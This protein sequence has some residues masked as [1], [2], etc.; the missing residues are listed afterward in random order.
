MKT[1]KL[2]PALAIALSVVALSGCT[3]NKHV[4]FGNYWNYDSMTQA[5]IQEK[6]TYDIVYEEGEGSPFCD[7]TIAYS[8]GTYT[9]ELKSATEGAKHVYHLTTTMSITVTYT[10]EGQEPVSKQDSVVT[11]TTFFQAGEHL[12]PISSEMTVLNHSPLMAQGVE[13]ADDCYMTVDYT[14]KTNYDEN[15]K[16]TIVQTNNALT[17]EK[18]GETVPYSTERTFSPDEDYCFLDHNQLAFCLRAFSNS[19][20]SGTIESYSPFTMAKQKVKVS[21]SDVSEDEAQKFLLSENGAGPAEKT[22]PYRKA[23]LDLD[24]DASGENWTAWIAKADNEK[25]NDNR[26]V[27]LRLETPLAYNLGS[28]VYNLKSIER[29]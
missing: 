26:N 3:G 16:G 18:D 17:M 13:K 25:K 2:I 19:T 23:T 12:R 6:L 15:G 11:K 20:T 10:L 24:V 9:T 28:L 1:K 21:F 27:M 14:I 5:D 7:Y 8:N 4:V 22:I 29:Q